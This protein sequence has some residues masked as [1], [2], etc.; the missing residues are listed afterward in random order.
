MAPDKVLILLETNWFDATK[1]PKPSFIVALISFFL[2]L[3]ELTLDQ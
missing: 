1:A 2:F 3:L